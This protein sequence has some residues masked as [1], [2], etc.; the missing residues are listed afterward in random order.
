MCEDCAFK[1]HE[2]KS[3]SKGGRILKQQKLDAHDSHVMDT[4]VIKLDISSPGGRSGVQD[5]YIFV[6]EEARKPPPP[7][8]RNAKEKTR[9]VKEK[10][11]WTLT[12]N[13]FI[14]IVFLEKLKLIIAL[15]RLKT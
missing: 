13:I 1:A 4:Q 11:K 7:R 6:L 2:K 12:V 15:V 3:F 10:S 9:R 8:L 14:K 5:E